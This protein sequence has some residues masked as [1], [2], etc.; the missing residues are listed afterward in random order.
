MESRRRERKKKEGIDMYFSGV[1]RYLIFQ[2]ALLGLAFP[3][4]SISQILR[5]PC[6]YDTASDWSLYVQTQEDSTKKTR[7]KPKRTG[8]L[9][10]LTHV[11]IVTCVHFQKKKIM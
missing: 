8:N 9:L 3:H 4:G 5:L 1:G 6:S 2:S 10:N 7:E 11:L